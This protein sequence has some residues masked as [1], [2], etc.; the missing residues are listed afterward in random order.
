[1]GDQKRLETQAD[2]GPPSE[3]RLP[4]AEAVQ[5]IRAA[6]II[7]GSRDRLIESLMGKG[8]SFELT[9]MDV[10]RT[11][12]MFSD[13]DFRDGRTVTGTIDGTAVEVSVLWPSILN[14]EVDAFNRGSSYPVQG[15]V[16]SWAR[17]RLRPIIRAERI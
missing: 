7:T 11:I 8:F 5:A 17:L 12:A 1:M 6:D 10:E 3:S 9:V 2:T 15:T 13:P 14:D 4:L 16:A